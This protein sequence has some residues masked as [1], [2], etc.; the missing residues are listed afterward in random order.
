MINSIK[1]STQTQEDKIESL[2]SLNENINEYISDVVTIDEEAADAINKSKDDFYDK[3]YYLK[4][5]CEKNVWEHIK[6]GCKKIGEWCK[7]HWDNFVESLKEIINELAAKFIDW[8]GQFIN[9]ASFALFIAELVI[10]FYPTMEF[11]KFWTKNDLP[12]AD[13][14]VGLIGAVDDDNDGVYHIRQDWF[15]SW[16]PLGYNDGYDNVFDSAI[17]ASGNTMDKKKSVQFEVDF[18]GD[19]EADKTYM[20]W[21]WKGD[22]MNLGA[23]TETGMYEY[24]SDT[25][26]LTA[27]DKATDMELTL[28][29]NDEMRCYILIHPMVTKIF[30]ITAHNG[31]LQDLMQEH[32]MLKQ[33]T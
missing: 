21:S 5:E 33:R 3:Y 20:F 1:S 25:H 19:G 10:T 22:Y 11:I 26:W 13:Q 9:T 32:K 16:G 18:D 15:Q 6:D 8:V 23:G 27:T 31:G 14:F 7:E 12:G 30:G 29:Y 17:R 4:P 24:Y 28:Y 2:E